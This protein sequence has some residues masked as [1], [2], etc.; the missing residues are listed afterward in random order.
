M[1][2]RFILPWTVLPL[3]KSCNMKIIVSRGV[4]NI[5]TRIRVFKNGQL[6]AVCPMR[7]DYCVFDAKEGDRVV[8]K[9]KYVTIASFVYHEGQ[10][11]FYISPTRMHRI[12]GWLNF[13]VFPYLTLVL[14]VFKAMVGSDA[15]DWL[16]TGMLVITV[17]SLMLLSS[18]VL[19][20]RKRDMM[21]RLDVL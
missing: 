21:F 3:E 19:N 12:W 18:C 9:L 11:T 20:P 10:D 5:F 4:D 13:M 7:K 6:I 17:L 1:V 14:F 8:I 2:G 15:Y 16:C